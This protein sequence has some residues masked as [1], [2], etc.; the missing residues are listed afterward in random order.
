MVPEHRAP[1]RLLGARAQGTSW[2]SFA[3]NEGPSKKSLTGEHVAWCLPWAPVPAA[4]EGG[5]LP[6]ARLLQTP[7]NWKEAWEWGEDEVGSEELR[8]LLVPHPGPL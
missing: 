2:K 8:R 6:H 1:A 3:R 7:A 4:A 5:V